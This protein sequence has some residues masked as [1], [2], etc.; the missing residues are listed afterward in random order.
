[1]RPR[2]IVPVIVV[3]GVGLVL[4]IVGLVTILV[5]GPV[6]SS[7]GEFRVAGTGGGLRPDPETAGLFVPEF[8]MVDQS[9]TPRTQ[10]ILDGRITVLDFIFTNCPFACPIMTSAMSDVADRLRGTG[11][12][13]LSVSVDP[14]HDTPARL[15]E[16]AKAH[17]AD[18][19]RW[20]FLTGDDQTV[21]RI[22]RGSLQFLL[23]PDTTRTIPIGDGQ[24]MNNIMHPTRLLLIGP[25]RQVLG[26]YEPQSEDDLKRLEARARA[27]AAHAR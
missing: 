3:C 13:F 4:S 23:Q 11:V 16:F 1:M 12:R 14:A 7:Q 15:T 17:G 24:Q 22:V 9:G 8:S 26:M 6:Y 20:T 21:H 27:A 2:W 5:R 25:D 18:L 10:A 19:S